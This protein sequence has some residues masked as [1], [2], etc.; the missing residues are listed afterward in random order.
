MPNYG[1]SDVNHIIDADEFN[2]LFNHCKNL[3]EKTWLL[4]LWLTGARPSELLEMVK[5][6]VKIESDKV[7]FHVKTLKLKK[8]KQF[9]VTSRNLILNTSS[10]ERYIKTLERH[11]SR[12]KDDSKI[13]QFSRKTGYN[14]IQKVG[15]EV[16]GKCLCPYN[17]RH[18]R[19]TLLAE[20]GASM[21]KLKMFKGSRSDSSVRPYLHIRKVSYDVEMDV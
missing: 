17:F 3:T 16:T 13:F 21:E 7:Q 14:I 9:M 19:M 6:D 10:I 12:L 2:V 20:K 1:L 18:S 4:M 15:Y 5:K 8:S 11:L